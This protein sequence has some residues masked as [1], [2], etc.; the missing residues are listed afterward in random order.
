MATKNIDISSVQNR[1]YGKAY[2]HD[3]QAYL[4]AAGGGFSNGGD[5]V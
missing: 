5:L 1:F 4:A 2:F 3:N